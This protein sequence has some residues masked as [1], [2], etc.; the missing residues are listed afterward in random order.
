MPAILSKQLIIAVAVAAT[1]ITISPT[2]LAAAD[3]VDWSAE[4][5]VYRPQEMLTFS[6]A[7]Y[8]RQHARHLLPHA[9]LISHVAGET[10]VSPRLLLALME[11]QSG[12]LS[13]RKP[14]KQQWAAPFGTLSSKYGFRA[15]LEDVSQQLFSA[16]Y[17]TAPQQLKRTDNAA[18]DGEIAQ[19]AM[20]RFMEKEASVSGKKA[21]QELVTT[22]QKLFPDVVFSETIDT[23]NKAAAPMLAPPFEL[24]QLA[25][26]VGQSWVSGGAHT[27]T[28]SGSYPLSSLDFNDG[29]YW[30]DNLSNKWVT[31]AAPGTVKVH[32][33]CNVEVIHGGGWSTQYYH[34]QNV[35]VSTNQNINRDQRLANYASNKS[36][37]LCQGGSSTG[38]HVHFT[39]KYN[40]Q[41]Y[42]LSDVYLSGYKVHPGNTSYDSN[43][44]R[45]WFEEGGQKW[46]AWSDMYNSGVVVVDT[47]RETEPNNTIAQAN[48]AARN[49]ITLGTINST[50]DTDYFK[51][52]LSANG[53]IA[54]TLT[55]VSSADYDLYLLNSAGTVLAKSEKSTGL[56]DTINYSASS[57]TYY[58]QIKYYGGTTGSG[59]TYSIRTNW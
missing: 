4:H 52:V 3:A 40:G 22:Y 39:L 15:Q 1:S 28:G 30:G 20:A 24:L 57:G 14:T 50:T 58:V 47:P 7:D 21:T 17:Q 48:N 34:L 23:T 33:S 44:S 56:V 53:S 51:M 25:W 9:E 36:Q 31:S 11:Q 6:V 27:T 46:C 42:H 54:L 26:P 8:L 13:N 37:A 43:C 29:G 12:L 19:H 32:S 49:D 45:F 10:S 2:T 16:I 59:G 41:P 55:P 38:P 18:I 5:I 35:Q